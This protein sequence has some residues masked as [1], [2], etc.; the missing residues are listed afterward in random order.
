MKPNIYLGIDGVILTRGVIPALYLD[1]FLKYLMENFTV[2]WLSS[3][4][5][6]SSETTDKYLSQFLPKS[7]MDLIKK[8]KPTN[9][10]L[11]RTEA[12]D[13]S[14][15]FFWLDKE[16][17]DSEKNTLK[18]HNKYNSWIELNLI[19]CPNQL[20]NIINSK[21]TFKNN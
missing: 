12:I 15:N 17:F 21:N 7:T 4:C 19:D 11:D 3:R 6:G 9:F 10:S 13:F 14:K 5:R 18:A 8:I 2:S 16:L 20:L 1:R